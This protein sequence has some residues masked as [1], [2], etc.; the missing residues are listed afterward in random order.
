MLLCLL[1]VPALYYWDR[2]QNE[3]T[4]YGWIHTMS[5]QITLS[6]LLVFYS[7]DKRQNL[8]VALFH[9]SFCKEYVKK[10]YVHVE[11]FLSKAFL[12]LLCLKAEIKA[13]QT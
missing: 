1:K 4:Y 5:F 6:P 13:C 8:Y 12:I 3:V 9:D 10:K 2:V 11:D 7:T